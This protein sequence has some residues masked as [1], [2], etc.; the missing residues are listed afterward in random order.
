MSQWW[1]VLCDEEKEIDEKC[2]GWK[3]FRSGSGSRA[4]TYDW[5]AASKLLLLRFD[6]S[7]SDIDESRLDC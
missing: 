4:V 1:T 6:C 7:L 3:S 2:R 5:L